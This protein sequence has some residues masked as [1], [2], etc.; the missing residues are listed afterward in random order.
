MILVAALLMQA[1]A[2]VPDIDFDLG[3]MPPPGRCEPGRADEIVVCGRT[4]TELQRLPPL[5]D[6]KYAEAPPNAEMKLFGDVVGS[7]VMESEGLPGGGASD[8][9]MVRMKIPF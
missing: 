7:A 1:A 5:P 2:T 6:A 9:I 4:D 3:D 8:R